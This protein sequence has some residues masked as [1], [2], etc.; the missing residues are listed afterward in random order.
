MSESAPAFHNVNFHVVEETPFLGVK[1]KTEKDADFIDKARRRMAALRERMLMAPSSCVV[2][3]IGKRPTME[4]YHVCK[5]T[6]VLPEGRLPGVSH[7]SFFAI[8]D[9]HGGTEAAEFLSRVLFDEIMQNVIRDPAN[10]EEA[11]RRAF[12]ESD[13]VL[14]GKL[15]DEG[16]SIGSTAVAILI[17]GKTLYCANVGDAEAFVGRQDKS[18]GEFARPVGLTQVHKVTLPEEKARIESVG[19]HI[20]GG[21]LFGT[22]AI[23]RA[24]GDGEMKVPKQEANYVS[25]V[26]HIVKMELT[27]G[28]GLSLLS[29]F[30]LLK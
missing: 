29:L 26:P 25:C 20:F 2:E 5:D 27:P 18:K 22:L 7:V 30:R 10:V 4:D 6:V 14:V 16:L 28:S 11:M 13:R 23:S 12:V 24:F 8:Y 3:A 1:L 9:G 17:I 15:G 21:R 19:G